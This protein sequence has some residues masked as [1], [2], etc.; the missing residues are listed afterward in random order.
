MHDG[1]LL[2]VDPSMVAEA[3]RLLEISMEARASLLSIIFMQLNG[4]SP[5]SFQSYKLNG[6]LFLCSIPLRAKVKVGK[7]WVS[8]EPLH[9]EP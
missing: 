4:I 8:L 9:L 1:F 2:E 5:F 7:T 3:V 6:C